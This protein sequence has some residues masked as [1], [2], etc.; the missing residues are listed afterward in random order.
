[1]SAMRPTLVATD[2]A[3]PKMGNPPKGT[4]MRQAVPPAVNGPYFALSGL[5]PA[6]ILTAMR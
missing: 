6:L 2:Q 1:M 5:I 4:S 3:A